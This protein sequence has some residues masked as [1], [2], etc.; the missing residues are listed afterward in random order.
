MNTLMTR[1]LDYDGLSREF[2]KEILCKYYP[3]FDI[4][5]S[6]RRYLNVSASDISSTQKYF[7]LLK[8]SVRNNQIPSLQKLFSTYVDFTTGSTGSKKIC[9]RPSV[10]LHLEHLRLRDLLDGILWSRGT[11]IVSTI[12]YY[13]RYGTSTFT[14]KD[15][16]FPELT[17]KKFVYDNVESLYDELRKRHAP[18]ILSGTPSS[19]VDLLELGFDC[20]SPELVFIAG[21]E[22]PGK[23]R[24]RIENQLGQVVNLIAAREF[25]LLG[26]EC[27]TTDGYHFFDNTV[28][29]TSNGKGQLLVSEPMNYCV[30]YKNYELGDSVEGF[31]QHRCSCFFRG[32]YVSAYKGRPYGK[33]YPPL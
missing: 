32:P 31:H 6:K 21:E 33:A 19:I 28:R 2:F 16:I 4:D 25:G 1:E 26:F 8:Q 14:Y 29:C 22:C 10:S 27:P 11:Q 18:Y 3:Q 23:I 9:I 30:P 12:F 17:M 7:E 24:L 5:A 13:S 15:R 20:F